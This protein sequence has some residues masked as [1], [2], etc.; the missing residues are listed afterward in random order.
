MT[1]R[2]VF[3]VSPSPN[4]GLSSPSSLQEKF[5]SS[6]LS[7][8]YEKSQ[9]KFVCFGQE[10]CEV[11]NWM[12]YNRL[13]SNLLIIPTSLQP[14]NIKILSISVLMSAVMPILCLES[15]KYLRGIIEK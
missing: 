9:V 12:R 2:S 10:L 11:D 5:S 7:P 6:S 1:G 8:L 4:P 14:H 15:A 3:D 13:S